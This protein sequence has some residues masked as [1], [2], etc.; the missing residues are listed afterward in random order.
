MG[1]PSRDDDRKTVTD[2]RANAIE[3]HL[4]TALLHAKELIQFVDFDANVLLG[5]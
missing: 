1:R 4:A 2:R 5:L 3:N